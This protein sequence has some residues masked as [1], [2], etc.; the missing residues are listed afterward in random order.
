MANGV[1]ISRVNRGSSEDGGKLIHIELENPGGK[2][3]AI[4]TKLE[5]MNGIIIAL[6]QL[7]DLALGEMA[8]RPG[9][10][11][12]NYGRRDGVKA[13]STAVAQSPRLPPMVV[14]HVE[15]ESST[16]HD[17]MLTPD[18]A[19]QIGSRL[20]QDAEKARTSK[21]VRPS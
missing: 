7:Y 17:L 19:D 21:P 20:T 9:F 12:G 6:S 4:M 8:K 1:H 13:F 5:D 11:I 18:L 3:L 14:L 15:T 16:S 10:N 2:P